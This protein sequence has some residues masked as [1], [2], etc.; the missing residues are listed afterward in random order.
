MKS[1]SAAQALGL[2]TVH[3]PIGLWYLTR[4]TGLIA[5]MLL[6]SVVV[7][8]TAVSQGWS[9]KRWPRFFSQGLHGYL[10]LLCLALIAGHVL[11]TVIDGFVPIGFLDAV[12]PFRSPYRSFWLG[13]GAVG[14]DLFMALL[15]TSAVRHRIGY[16]NWKAIH[17]L[18]YLCWPVA[19]FHGLRMGT[20][21]R[22]L[23][24]L[25]INAICVT[26]VLAAVGCR[27][28]GPP[29]GR[30]ALGLTGRRSLG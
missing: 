17:W 6:S 2:A 11:T 14:F 16:R 7:L 19:V 15:V 8:G 26:A 21:I 30:R 3:G 13:L 5:L 4:G 23:P 28:A 24:V 18:A 1:A 9:S 20:D 25:V 10:S 29:A 22:L 12:I 27:L